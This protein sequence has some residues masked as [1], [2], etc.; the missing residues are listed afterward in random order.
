[1]GKLFSR[2]RMGDAG[3]ILIVALTLASCSGGGGG[4]ATTTNTGTGAT[5]STA[6]AIDVTK[7]TET[8]ADSLGSYTH[9]SSSYNTMISAGAKVVNVSQLNTWFLVWL[10]SDYSSQTVRRVMIA[11]HGTGGTAYA[12]AKDELSWAQANHYAVLAPQWWMSATDS[13]LDP[14]AVYQVIDAG[15]RYLIWKYGAQQGKA[16][17][18]GFSRGSSISYE[19]TYWDKAGGANYI[20]FT[21]SH[22]GGMPANQPTPFFTKVT[23]GA[24]GATPF[25]G[26]HF[27]MYCGMLDEEWGT[28]MCQY[29]NDA[30]TLIEPRGA[31]IERFIQD[32][33][34]GHAGY[35]TLS[36]Y[37]Q[38]AVQKFLALTP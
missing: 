28:Q 16:A 21:I 12:E 3:L 1:M 13:Y 11:T 30:R 27:Y 37:H 5:T 19:V 23:Q 34:G 32:A 33:S 10:P 2:R 17:Y 38:V 35:K 36:D 25:S 7:L 31:T 4:V 29:M 14:A 8:T 24:Y 6:T 20:A 22:S 15:M 9:D 26:A 18:E